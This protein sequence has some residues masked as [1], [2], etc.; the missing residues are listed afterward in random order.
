MNPEKLLASMAEA[1]ASCATYRDSGRVLTRFLETDGSPKHTSDRPFRTA[2]VR[3][4][5][6]RF[7]FQ[8]RYRDDGEWHRYI[9][10]ADGTHVR[11]WSHFGARLEQPESISLAIAGG[12]GVSGASAHTIPVLLMPERV[13]G[14]RLTELVDLHLVGEELIDEFPCHRLTGTFVPY[15][16]SADEDDALR[17]RAV[18]T[19]MPLPQRYE[20]SP[21]TLWVDSHTFL[22]RRIENHVRFETFRTETVTTYSPGLNVAVADEES[23]FDAPE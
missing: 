8:N 9:I 2:F 20:H 19:G 10:W 1:Y 15:A 13:S 7:E 21:H 18:L 22:L 23:G 3:P 4:S 5:H 12:T 6:F 11:V 16:R 17:Q 14:R